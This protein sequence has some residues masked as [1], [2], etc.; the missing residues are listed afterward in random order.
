MIWHSRH[1]S[2]D[3][4]AAADAKRV[5]RQKKAERSRQGKAQQEAAEAK[6]VNNWL[7]RCRSQ[8]EV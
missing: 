3:G 6:R 5:K 4:L 8:K 2:K 7:D 1:H